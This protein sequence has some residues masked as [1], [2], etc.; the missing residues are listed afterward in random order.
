MV[1]PIWHALAFAAG[2]ALLVQWP[3]PPGRETILALVVAGAAA[4]LTAAWARP[5]SL[6]GCFLLGVGWAGADATERARR[7]DASLHNT[8]RYV[9]GVV[10]GLV[11]RRGTTLSFRLHAPLPGLDDARVAVRWYEYDSGVA[12]PAPG[13]TWRLHLRLRRPRGLRNPG[14]AGFERY[15]FRHGL[16]A[17]AYVRAGDNQRLAPHTGLRI[18]TVRAS[19]SQRIEQRLGDGVAAA[20]IT[21]LAVG[22]RQHLEQHHWRILRRTGLTHLM[23]ISGLHIGM[24]AF[25]GYWIG[26]WAGSLVNRGIAGGCAC[27]IALGMLYALLAGLPLPTLRALAVVVVL[28]SARWARRSLNRLDAFAIA[29]VAVL[30]V[31]PVATI[32][33]GFWLSFGAV[34]ALAFVTAGATGRDPAR[35]LGRAQLAVGIGLAPALLV[36]FGEL[37][38]VAPLVNVLALPVAGFVLV[39]G[40][41]LATV[42][43]LLGIDAGLA[44]LQWLAVALDAAWS[45]L[46]WIARL[47]FA[48]LAPGAPPWHAVLLG[49]AGACWWLAPAGWP[50]RPLG[51]F[52]CAGLWLSRPASP[53]PGELAL[54][55]LDVGHGVA[56]VARTAR[57][58]LVYDTGPA[59]RGGGNAGERLVVPYLA[60]LRAGLDRIVVS[61]GDSDHAGGAAALVGAFPGAEVLAG[62]PA[63]HSYAS[64]ACRR[65]ERWS[66]DGVGFSFLHP[67][68]ANLYTGNDASCVLRIDV[69][70]YCVL[71]A[72]DI[73]ARAER[74][75]LA[76]RVWLSCEVVLIPHHGSET[77]SHPGFVAAVPA[78]LAVSST[79]FANR[80]GFPRSAVV[81]RWQA[82]GAQLLDTG[83]DGAIELRIHSANGLSAT[84]ERCRRPRLWAEPCLAG[85]A[86]A[87][88]GRPRR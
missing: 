87:A 34:A 29:L 40:V 68:A 25:A 66:W 60:R 77:S 15:A 22:D 17:S 83:R 82:V 31:D 69:G 56:V 28:V 37:S 62:E 65:G 51:L 5:L 4:L 9:T 35:G 18:D 46:A 23:A 79:A 38:L 52:M 70:P 27:A 84:S 11:E 63:A 48:S 50:A 33:A 30:C 32:D 47:P 43:V 36:F 88:L 14:S 3:A 55:V 7:L 80:W 73:E 61:H 20:L 64:R 86:V 1:G 44:L 16:A 57:H 21:A 10:S 76:A 85:T 78:R 8:D 42:L 26:A 72:G 74:A 71:L 75:L 24:V 54:T 6:A 59:W 39:P 19:V 12:P 58:V 41:L 53:A 13:E 2:T 45:G 49:V 81:E 67:G